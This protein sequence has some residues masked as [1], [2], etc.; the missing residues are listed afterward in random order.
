MRRAAFLVALLAS[1]PAWARP[2][3]G[4][5]FRTGSTSSGSSSS[6]SSSWGSS[7]SSR[8]SSSSSWSWG[9]SGSSRSSSSSGSWG[10]SSRSSSGSTYSRPSYSPP[11]M[12][13]D[14][15]DRITE[16]SHCLTRCTSDPERSSQCFAECERKKNAPRPKVVIDE[17]A[18]PPPPPEPD[19]PMSSYFWVLGLLLGVVG[20]G[21]GIRHM[22][23]KRDEAFWATAT[24]DVDR[25]AALRAEQEA[26][27]ERFPS[28]AAAIERLR[29]Q[30]PGFSRVLFEDFL[31]ALYVEAQTARGGDPEVLRPWLSP[32]ALESLVRLRADE[33]KAVIV[34]SLET[35]EVTVDETA[36]KLVV[37]VA[38]DANYTELKGQK[39]ESFYAHEIW[40]L[41]RSADAKSRPP[42]RARVLD[43]AVCGAPVEKLVGGTCGHCGASLGEGKSDWL[44]RSIAIENR[45]LRG[46]LL[47]GTT[48]E[49]G[50]DLPTLVAPDVKSEF[51]AL[52]ARDPEFSWSAF[53][54]RIEL[55]FRTFHAAWAEQKLGPVRAYL[56]DSLF[57][58]QRYWVRAYVAQGLRNVTDE[59]RIVSVA[60]SRVVRDAHFDA[61][62]VRV[63]AECKD[64]TLDA[65]G[66]V[67]GGS[68]ERVRQYSE[69]WTF[70][71]SVER[72]GPARGAPECPSCGAPADG[73]DMAGTC[74]KCGVKVTT[75]EFDWVLSRIEQDEV[76][77]L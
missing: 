61:I 23:R 65:S 31:H 33:V 73:I 60:L 69:Y 49:E 11:A 76:Y 12:D 46:P 41:E 9:S 74:A 54:T 24:E 29:G 32:P 25:W 18:S 16:W 38:F 1:L 42:A 4:Q 19:R 17:S 67:V 72:R 58:L 20:V 34:G 70:I 48:E 21:G 26:A 55:V 64:F 30:D 2:G 22:Q 8:S 68:R 62:T 5:S 44:V 37:R 36:R 59:P 77:R 51:A 27:K 71:R 40:T 47:T 14:E 10:G 53:T 6:G 35:L 43:C 57:E 7:G 66:R 56:S 15:L 45:E 63:F 50:T 52:T 13:N 28:V 39:E 75:G 3:G